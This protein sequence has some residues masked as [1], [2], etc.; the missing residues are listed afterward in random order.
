MEERIM[1]DLE[2]FAS[3]LREFNI[4]NEELIKKFETMLRTKTYPSEHFDFIN[5]GAFKECY[6]LTPDFIIK[7]NSSNNSTDRENKVL[8][9]AQRT[10]LSDI[11]LPTKFYELKSST[12]PL[13]YLRE[14]SNDYS[15]YYDRD[16][17]PI[18]FDSFFVQPF[19]KIARE[20]SNFIEF[21]GDIPL[22]DEYGDTIPYE[23][24][25]ITAYS[26]L[27]DVLDMYGRKFF[28]M[29]INFFK[30]KGMHDLHPEN[31]GY[32]NNKPIILDWLSD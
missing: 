3:I 7:F 29:M 16:L 32:F 24:T 13:C 4:Y 31:I 11:F 28:D 1:E 22:V 18:S 27:K 14:E 20:K 12:I 23:L 8:A 15:S 10:G 17:A 5:C 26:W 25:T 2:G 19:A 6:Q 21:N 9:D 30:A